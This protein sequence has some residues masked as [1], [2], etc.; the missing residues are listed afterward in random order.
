MIMLEK[1]K[2]KHTFIADAIKI[3]VNGGRVQMLY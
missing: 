3:S 1:I 2:D